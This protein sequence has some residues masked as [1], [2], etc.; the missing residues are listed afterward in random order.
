MAK[1]IELKNG[2]GGNASTMALRAFKEGCNMV[3][4]GHAINEEF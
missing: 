4:L 3:I 1:K 2:L